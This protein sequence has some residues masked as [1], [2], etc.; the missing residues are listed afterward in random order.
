MSRIRAT[1]QLRAL[2]ARA[3]ELQQDVAAQQISR[4]QLLIRDGLLHCMCESLSFIQLSLAS[5][6]YC[7]AQQ[8]EQ[9]QA[10]R[11]EE[12][13]FGQLLQSE[14]QLLEQL[15]S[16]QHLGVSQPLAQVLVPEEGT[17]CL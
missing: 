8:Q 9:Q 7:P 13:R 1:D 12:A 15:S 16:K 14:V 17:I 4:R 6:I 3:Q 10:A 11:E 5:S 2:Q